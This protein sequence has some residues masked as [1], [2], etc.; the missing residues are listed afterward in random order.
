MK[1][2][3]YSWNENNPSKA[4]IRTRTSCNYCGRQFK[5]EWTKKSHE[6][7]CKTYH[8]AHIEMQDM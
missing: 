3:G 1:Q 7:S 6:S 4:G 2:G 5:Q 8:D